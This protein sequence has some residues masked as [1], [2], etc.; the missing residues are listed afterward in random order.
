MEHVSIYLAG[1]IHK[2]HER[3]NKAH[4]TEEDLAELEQALAPVQ[5]AFLNP[6]E[7]GDDLSD[8]VGLFGRDM[9]QVFCSDVVLVDARDRRGLGV[10][11]EMMWAKM[12]HI[13]VVT[14]APP[15]TH[16]RRSDTQLLG[17]PVQD[18]IHPFVHGLSDAIAADLDGAASWIRTNVCTPG[19]TIKGPQFIRDA[20]EYY[21]EQQLAGD[22]PMQDLKAVNKI[23]ARRIASLQRSQ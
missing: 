16:Y 5:V 13:P 21:R 3:P 23:V 14:L 10:G 15:E 8:T 4:W 6:A 20:M 11:S 9:M 7:R 22:I 1:K 17:Q 2:G 19:Q 12:H 18:Y